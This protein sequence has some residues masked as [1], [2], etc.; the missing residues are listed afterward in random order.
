MA[1]TLLSILLS[2]PLAWAT[3]VASPGCT[4]LSHGQ[5]AKMVNGM[6]KVEATVSG[7]TVDYPATYGNYCGKQAEPGSS[8]CWNLTNDME[9]PTADQAGWCNDPWCYVD[10]CTCPVADLAMSSYFP[11]SGLYYS[12]S[13]CGGVDTFTSSSHQNVVANCAMNYTPVDA[14]TCLVKMSHGQEK[15]A[16]T[17]AFA[18]EGKCV[19]ASPSGTALEY[20]ATY[21]EGCGV[22]LEPGSSSC[23]DSS[24]NALA[25]N[26]SADWC[27]KPWSYVNPCTCTASDI[28][29]TT[30]F[31]L[32]L[33]YS[34]SVCGSTDTYTTS[35]SNVNITGSVGCPS[36]P[37]PPISPMNWPFTSALEE[38]CSCMPLSDMYLIAST[39]ASCAQGSGKCANASSG[40]L[41]ANYGGSCGIHAELFSSSCFDQDTGMMWADQCEPG[42]TVGC[43]AAW[44]DRPWCY[45]DPCTCSSATDIAASQYFPGSTLYYS[46][47]NCKSVDTF[48]PSGSSV[49]ISDICPT[50][51]NV[52]S[53]SG[54]ARDILS[55]V[56][57]AAWMLL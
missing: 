31:N 18:K 35:P 34:Y 42:W 9:L 43:R 24:G 54:A 57:L 23:S 48:T 13:N 32:E 46:Y 45:I 5:V 17:K 47:A 56:S 10:P 2:T 50:T 6:S 49:D 8:S 16:C 40:M 14:A 27:T 33:Y 30:Y 51:T 52:V 4:C 41:T 12:Y 7:S 39:D 44:C 20:P 55:L 29:L 53:T 21:G 1:K 22:H 15:V 36:P 19:M 28:A 38:G 11:G 37:P 3:S 25:R 26:E